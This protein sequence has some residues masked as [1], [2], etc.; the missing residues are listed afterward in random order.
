MSTSII[1][2]TVEHA[3]P[4]RSSRGGVTVFKSIRFQLDDGSS[5]TVVKSVVQRDV[6]AEF[7]PGSKARFYLF[8]AFDIS[9]VHGVRTP[10]GRAIYAFPGNNQRI[11]LMAGIANLA[12][13]AVRLATDGGI[14]ILALALLILSVVGWTLMSKGRTEAKAQFDGDAGYSGTPAQAQTSPL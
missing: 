12:W 14:P 13:I 3:V 9:G 7:T 4:G 10:D 8:K 1:D 5:H 2:G 6:A 11:F